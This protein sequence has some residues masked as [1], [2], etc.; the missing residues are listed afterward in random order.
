[1]L[2]SRRVTSRVPL[3]PVPIRR[4]AANETKDLPRAAGGGLALPQEDGFFEGYASL[5][6]VVDLGR[7]VVVPGAFGDSLA[8]RGPAGVR[9]LWQH[10]PNQPLGAWAMLREDEKGLFV[11]GRL[12]PSVKRAREALA[13]LRQGA[14]DGLSIGYRTVTARTEARTGVRRL[15]RVDL[16]EISLVT[17]P[18]LPQARVTAVKASLASADPRSLAGLERR[19]PRRIRRPEPQ[20]WADLFHLPQAP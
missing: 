3:R 13:L 15:L 19:W 12:N 7:D 1:M 14:I 9:L 8:R 6:G 5:F 11:R 2:H 17:F 16:W 18:L 10:D 4:T 20:G